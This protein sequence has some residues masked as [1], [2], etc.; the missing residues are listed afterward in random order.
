MR[1][2]IIPCAGQSTR[3]NTELPKWL[4]EHPSGKTMV[5][6]SIQGL[7]LDT[8]DRIIIV[9]LKKHLND[10]LRNKI[11]DEFEGYKKFSLFELGEDTKSASDTVSQTIESLNIEGSIF[12][13]DSDDYFYVDS[14]EPNQICTY[15]LND[16]KNI[17]PGNKSYIKKNSND[18][19]LTIVE[20]KVI[21][22][23]F[24]CGMYSFKDAKEF[25][26]VYNSIEQ[27][28]EIYISHVIF[29]ML[30]NGDSFSSKSTENFLDWGTQDDWDMFL[31]NYIFI[32]TNTNK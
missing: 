26:R 13:K 21:S 9:A 25:V 15:S 19:V 20:K 28:D 18:E 16:C 10:E 4:L 5:Y 22:S 32:Y 17:T 7:P 24:C 6:E 29:K 8:F 11:F 12:I 14:V 30:L 27:D 3:F 31:K 2:L 23:D 1:T